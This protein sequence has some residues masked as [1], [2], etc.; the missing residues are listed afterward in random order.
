MKVNISDLRV[1]L[2]NYSGAPVYDSI[3]YEMNEALNEL[4][5][6]RAT[7]RNFDTQLEA[8]NAQLRADL[9]RITEI[10]DR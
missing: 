6:H 3:R 1:N 10:K 9:A 2:N 5:L 4:E 8:N 7:R